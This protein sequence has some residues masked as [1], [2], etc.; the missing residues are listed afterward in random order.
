[1]AE[2]S[3][4]LARIQG[5]GLVETTTKDVSMSGAALAATPAGAEMQGRG[6]DSAKMAGTA[7]AKVNALRM[8]IQDVGSSRLAALRETAKADL[9]MDARTADIQ[10]KS[11]IMGRIDSAIS[12]YIS[13]IINN[14]FSSSILKNAG[15]QLKPNTYTTNAER[16][17]LLAAVSLIN[18][19]K[20]PSVGEDGKPLVDAKGQ[21]VLVDATGED[22]DKAF[23]LIN[24]ALSNM[25]MGQLQLV[26]GESAINAK[27]VATNLFTNLT[28]E[29]M[30]QAF[31]K[32][33]LA[34]KGETEIADFLKSA[35]AK[36]FA[37]AEGFKDIEGGATAEQ[38]LGELI[39]SIL[40][41]DSD[42][43]KMQL[44]DM[45][46]AI[47]KWRQ[48][49]FKD[50]AKYQ[51]ILQS[52]SASTAQRQF[53]A[54]NLRRLGKMG[55]I[56][57]DEKVGNLEAQMQ[58]GDK[59]KIG[60][61]TSY[62]EFDIQ[63][64]FTK[65]EQLA[66]LRNWLAN[67]DS[68]PTLLKSWIENN[69]DAIANKI[70]ELE[71]D[72]KMMADKVEANMK[73]LEI[74]HPSKPDD[75]TLKHFFGENLFTPTV[76]A[77]AFASP[78]Q[79]AKYKMLQ[80]KDKGPFIA[81]LLTELGPRSAKLLGTGI[82]GKEI[83]DKLTSA[84]LDQI[85]KYGPVQFVDNLI[86][87]TYAKKFAASTTTFTGDTFKAEL[88]LLFEKQLGIDSAG[89]MLAG[90][91]DQDLTE[92]MELIPTDSVLSNYIENNKFNFSKI[93]ELL[94]TLG[95][96]SF[97]SMA[98]G[99]SFAAFK[100]DINKLVDS[101]RRVPAPVEESV[102]YN[103]WF[104]LGKT[105]RSTWKYH[106]DNYGF[107]EQVGSHP[108]LQLERI[109]KRIDDVKRRATEMYP[110]DKWEVRFDA[111]GNI[112]VKRKG[113][114]P[115][116]AVYL[117]V[118][119]STKSD[120]YTDACRMAREYKTQFAIQNHFTENYSTLETKYKDRL[121]A[122]VEKKRSQ[123]KKTYDTKKERYDKFL[124]LFGG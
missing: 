39:K 61:E 44:S 112:V 89:K 103:K 38:Q 115:N 108:K 90:L 58:D 120:C 21:P 66:R 19:N 100:K 104:E 92:F 102:D 98:T 67:P 26:K 59:L 50:V 14:Q 5:Q 52:G 12:G 88:G 84:D 53:A 85:V 40:P 69:R 82:D 73:I 116:G 99:S 111:E 13:E 71:P 25:G 24:K 86:S 3:S 87:S 47:Q 72:F 93:K 48:E 10:R 56:A 124:A 76:A 23:A 2:R 16:D 96:G 106:E 49:E 63:D 105:D 77:K 54:E 15:A 110:S 114:G 20:K 17:A 31:A 7:P 45:T 121:N 30:A 57:L 68:A 91:V 22:Y 78:E 117:P 35:D 51:E 11:G 74:T 9:A 109:K 1:M 43:T 83:F 81:G 65:P 70:E 37:E 42:L 32:D 95:D 33:V 8:A 41:P 36:I 46:A 27:S 113:Q 64:F 80:D 55:T 97:D 94:K 101:V 62:E 4:A 79:E 29:Q 107:H 28:T 18:T 34:V 75:D 6:P 122:F 118:P 60:D 119:L 123:N